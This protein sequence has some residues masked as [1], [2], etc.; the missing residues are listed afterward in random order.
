MADYYTHF[1]CL[2]DVKTAENVRLAHTFY[3]TLKPQDGSPDWGFRLSSL[4][5]NQT[6]SCLWFTDD[7]TGVPDH[8]V[9]FVLHCANVFGLEGLWGFEWSHGCS[10][11]H[12][13]AYGGGAIALDLTA[14]LVIGWT[15]THEWLSQT[16]FPD[17]NIAA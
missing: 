1:S 17:M 14:G 5:I 2:L 11:P 13:D 15:N 6:N 8:V 16:L 3:E 10:K 9:E 12:L 7:T 4:V